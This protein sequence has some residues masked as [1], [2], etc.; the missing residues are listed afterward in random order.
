MDLSAA[1]LLCS[2]RDLV[3]VTYKKLKKKKMPSNLPRDQTETFTNCLFVHE[4]VD[5]IK[6][7]Y[8]IHGRFCV[9]FPFHINHWAFSSITKQLL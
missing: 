1:C 7:H 8:N 4:A 3:F 6:E 2:L 9:P 5:K